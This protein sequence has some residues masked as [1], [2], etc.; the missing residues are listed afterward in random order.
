MKPSQ[1][2]ALLTSST[3]EKMF[4]VVHCRGGHRSGFDFGRILHFF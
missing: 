3:G 1:T 2:L 4:I